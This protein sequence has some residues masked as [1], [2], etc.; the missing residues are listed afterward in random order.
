M[1]IS[2]VE[3]CQ[4]SQSRDE[5]EELSS[6]YVTQ[7]V[8]DGGNCMFDA[9]VRGL[10]S[11]LFDRPEDDVEVVARAQQLRIQ[12]AELLLHETLYRRDFM[13]SLQALPSW[14]T[15]VHM[16]L[17]ARNVSSRTSFTDHNDEEFK[18]WIKNWWANPPMQQGKLIG[19][20]ELYGDRLI[21]K[22]LGKAL[23]KKIQVLTGA[24]MCDGDPVGDM[25]SNTLLYV[26]QTGQHY[27][28][29]LKKGDADK[30]MEKMNM[31]ITRSDAEAA[32]QHIQVLD[33][34]ITDT[35]ILLMMACQYLVET[36]YPSIEECPD[37][38]E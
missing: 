30:L 11:S 29:V 9:L 34:Q 31:Q 1:K 6:Q 12:A 18:A 20:V 33:G 13:Q 19:G 25:E 35:S 17:A 23:G 32:I 27:N 24:S 7:Q 28:A 8:L 36:K 10:N 5:V 16:W 14:D 37:F 2:N 38:F 22:I 3:G 21:L 26:Q 15:T 4:Q